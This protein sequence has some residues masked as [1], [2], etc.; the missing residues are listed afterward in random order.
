MTMSICCLVPHL[1][2][3]ARSSSRQRICSCDTSGYR[4]QSVPSSSDSISSSEANTC[5]AANM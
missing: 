1:G 3:S 5:E 2:R 4:L